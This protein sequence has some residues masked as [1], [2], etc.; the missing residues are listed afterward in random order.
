MKITFENM[1]EPVRLSGVS[2][3]NRLATSARNMRAD[4]VIP[5]PSGS[6]PRRSALKS[7]E[8]RAKAVDIFLVGGAFLFALIT[9][10]SLTASFFL[11]LFVET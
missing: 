9:A 1:R 4:L 7:A 6:I 11:L 8:I 2:S 10:L 5:F 3:T